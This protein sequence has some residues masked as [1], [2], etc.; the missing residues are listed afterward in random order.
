MHSAAT[1]PDTNITPTQLL[2]PTPGAKSAAP[3][4]TVYTKIFG[5]TVERTKIAEF[6]AGLRAL[7][8]RS[9]SAWVMACIDAVVEQ[10]AE[11]REEVSA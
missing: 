5:N 4:K 3:D 7:G 1:T 11:M 9:R 6:D 8:W 10:T 2:M